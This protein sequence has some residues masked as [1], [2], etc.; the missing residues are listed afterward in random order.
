MLSIYIANVILSCH[1]RL[2]DYCI[3]ECGLQIADQRGNE[4]SRIC[5]NRKNVM[6]DFKAFSCNKNLSVNFYIIKKYQ[7]QTEIDPYKHY[8]GALTHSN[9]I[10]APQLAEFIEL[11]FAKESIAKL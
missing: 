3:L 5:G 1:L 8:E 6:V 4:L 7:L 11:G 9:C 10:F 2:M